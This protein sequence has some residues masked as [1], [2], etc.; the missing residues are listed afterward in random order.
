MIPSIQEQLDQVNNHL[1]HPSFLRTLTPSRL[2]SQAASEASSSPKEKDFPSHHRASSF[3][4]LSL[5]PKSP[6]HRSNRSSFRSSDSTDSLTK[7]TSLLSFEH[8]S[9]V[10]LDLDHDAFH[11]LRES[12]S[13][14]RRA[15]QCLSK[16][17]GTQGFQAFNHGH[18]D[19]VLAVD[20]NFFGTRMVTASSD[21][22]LKVYDR[23]D[24]TWVLVDTW[25]AHDAE[26]VDV[27]WNGPFV[28]EVLGS[29]GE[30]GRFKVWQ[31][32]VTEPLNSG[33][34]F[35]L[36]FNQLSE[37]KVP[38]MSLDFK[39]I[40]QET[41]VALVSRDGNLYVGEPV[42]PGNLNDW[43]VTAKTPVI[44]QK[45]SFAEEASFRVSFHHEKLPCWTALQAGLDR[46]ALS[47]A[48]V[49]M[50][51][52]KIYRT[53]KHRR[54]YVAADLIGK[55]GV[56]VRDVAWA[57]GSMRGT[58]LIATAGKDGIVRIYELSTPE[59]RRPDSLAAPAP[60]EPARS[61]GSRNAP[62]GIGAGLAGASGMHEGL[63][64]DQDPGRIK[65]QVK[66]VAELSGHQGAVWRVAWSQM[67][68][69]LLST[70]DDGTIRSWKKGLKG[71]WLEFSEID[72]NKNS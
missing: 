26:V 13:K 40:M 68:D 15:W 41:W 72:A 25:R 42:D 3:S 45:P 63:L 44:P 8:G 28:G 30:D 2:P 50:D 48:V 58:D 52:V 19:L 70:G 36:L 65:H 49:A 32:D 16:K 14:A 38:Y 1:S 24:D 22:R 34:R 53:D 62:S 66:V 33:R 11:E 29:I 21:H 47:L 59:S 39:N 7:S 5:R 9:K 43:H 20:F 69:L 31:E 35:K 6:L 60:P 61:R 71:E 23:K 56:L 64:G 37:T 51:A 46:R 57:N 12:E 4:Q 18:Q 17:M 67:G 10:V 55:P 27:K 54:F